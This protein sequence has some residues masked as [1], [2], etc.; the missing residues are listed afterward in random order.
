LLHLVVSSPTV[1]SDGFFRTVLE[2]NPAAVSVG[3]M[4]G[5]L[6]LH[7]AA[8]Y[9]AGLEVVS[10]LLEA[11][12]AAASVSTKDG[13]LPIH[14]ATGIKGSRNKDLG[15]LEV[16]SALLAA[17]PSSINIRMGNAGRATCPSDGDG[18]LPFCIAK[19]ELHEQFTNMDID[20]D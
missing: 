13:L 8:S 12:K 19:A 9:G 16:F 20:E 18:D 3:D 7:L 6:P 14:M 15:W 2:Q 1:N 10:V 11:H 4:Y 17:Y 5:Q